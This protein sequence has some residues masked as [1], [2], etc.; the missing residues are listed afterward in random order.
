MLMQDKS[1]PLT[2]VGDILDKI[3]PKN[4]D[5]KENHIWKSRENIFLGSTLFF[6]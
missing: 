1:T 5:R 2:N 6:N 3:I 4:N